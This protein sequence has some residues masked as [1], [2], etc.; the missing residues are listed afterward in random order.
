MAGS[1]WNSNTVG[2]GVTVSANKLLASRPTGDEESFA[3]VRGA[4]GRAKGKRYFEV[5]ATDS[6]VSVG[7]VDINADIDAMLGAGTNPLQWGF[8]L[9]NGFLYFRNSIT[10]G[11]ED[12]AVGLIAPGILGV[13]LDLEQHEMTIY[14][15]GVELF[16]RSILF[17]NNSKLYPAVSMGVGVSDVELITKE[18]FR[19]PPLTNYV[20][21][22]LFDG[23]IISSVSGSMKIDSVAV[24]RQIKAFTYS[25]LTFQLNNI[26]IQE[27][28][29][30]GQTVSD[31]ATG[32]YKISLRDGYP[33]EV[34]V[35]AFDEYGEGFEADAAINLGDRIHPTVPTG[36][37]YE[38]T[39][40][41]ALPSSE[42][43]P[44]PT[45]P[46]ASHLIGTA[47][48]N[49]EPFY[50]PECHGPI[51]PIATLRMP[52]RAGAAIACGSEF[53]VAIRPDG[54]LTAWGYNNYGQTDVPSGGN[55]IQVAAGVH[56]AAALKSD[57]SVVAWGRNDQGQSSPPVLSNAVAIAAGDAHALALLAD[58]TVVTWGETN[59]GVGTIPSDLSAIAIAA[60][61][62]WSM[63][64]RADGSMEHWGL[65][66]YD[67]DNLPAGNNFVQ[68]AGSLH[69][70]FAINAAG[71]VFAWGQTA[72]NITAVPPEL[73]EP[74]QI[75]DSAGYHALGANANGV[76]FAW[77]KNDYGQATVPL[78]LDDVIAV[79]AG[80]NFSI[81]VKSDGT[82]VG[83]GRNDR[84]QINIPSGLVAKT[85]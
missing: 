11:S 8:W 42:P 16:T 39:G 80:L 60:G 22:D 67:I 61:D 34:F 33:D 77:G 12:M 9:N 13:L 31:A 27:S 44:W 40:S 14:V 4:A 37:V 7:V 23:S 73:N 21:W 53:T 41:G 25:R 74:V 48:F 83:W 62:R 65:T 2:A 24:A 84:G 58:G 55:V 10:N 18:P 70:C 57:G 20:P 51:K 72:D 47:S 52:I 64:I 46:E 81:A 19:Y 38:C 71:A 35:V 68:V 5:D 36:Y 43:N 45:D 3:G 78:E 79:S 54:T 75:A 6:S 66:N 59:G 26:P 82:V 17:A 76:V 28:K 32:N 1:G 50:R 63:A 49:V 29:P 15:D 56:F 69:S 85:E 30:L